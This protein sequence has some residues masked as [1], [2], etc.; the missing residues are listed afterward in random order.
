MTRYRFEYMFSD[1]SGFEEHFDAA[2]DDRAVSKACEAGSRVWAPHVRLVHKEQVKEHK[3]LKEKGQPKESEWT[4]VF[5]VHQEHHPIATIAAHYSSKFDHVLLGCALLNR[6]EGD[7][8]DGRVGRAKAVGRMCGLQRHLEG[9]N[10]P[11]CSR[12]H[13][14]PKMTA[15]VGLDEFASFRAQIAG[16]NQRLCIARTF[17][18]KLDEFDGPPEH[19]RKNDDDSI[20]S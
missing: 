16:S 12:N 20:P 3:E 5:H 2:D 9:C 14:R 7:S 17:G 19:H 4:R 10:E 15:S 6:K 13:N 11:G 8:F 1:T 18:L